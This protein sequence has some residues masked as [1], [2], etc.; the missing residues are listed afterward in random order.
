MYI[1]HTDCILY[2]FMVI[3]N[4]ILYNTVVYFR[5][6][7]VAVLYYL[8]NMIYWVVRIL[9]DPVIIYYTS[10]NDFYC[11]FGIP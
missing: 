7:T 11:V 9:N 5:Y 1:F 10:R 3:Y 8:Q 4:K 2:I 6:N